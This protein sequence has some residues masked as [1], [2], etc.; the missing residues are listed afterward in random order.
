MFVYYLFRSWNSCRNAFYLLSD[1][2][3]AG[4]SSL[5]LSEEQLALLHSLRPR[6]STSPVSTSTRVKENLEGLRS[7]YPGI[8][9]SFAPPGEVFKEDGD[10]CSPSGGKGTTT[11]KVKPA[12]KKMD[13]NMATVS[14]R[15]LLE[16][17]PLVA[18]AVSG[19]KSLPVD[20]T[21]CQHYWSDP[22]QVLH[23]VREE[24]DPRD[25]NMEVDRSCYDVERLLDS[26]M[27][28]TW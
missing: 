17:N 22:R 16:Q 24:E 28:S 5:Q 20:Q 14:K 3:K 26:A 10:D 11:G 2:I 19:G 15:K 8:K 25:R 4:D 12:K 1:K 7:R 6:P 27:G 21:S 9:I 18:V 13:R 23:D